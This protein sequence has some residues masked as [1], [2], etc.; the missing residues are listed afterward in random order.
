MGIER[1]GGDAP[2]MSHHLVDVPGIKSGIGG[3]MGG[4]VTEGGHGL[5]VQGDEVG[6]VVLIEGLG[7]LGEG[8]IAIDRISRTGDSRA[9]AKQALLLL[10]RGAIGLLLIAALLDAQPRIAVAGGDV[11]HVEGA[12]DID[13]RIVFAHPGV[14][15]GDIESH[16]FAQAGDLLAQRLHGGGKEV[17][18]QTVRQFPL[19][20]AQP[21]ITGDGARYI[22]ALRLGDIHMQAKAWFDHQQGM[23]E[24]EGAQVGARGKAFAHFDEQGFE[25][26]AQRIRTTTRFRW[27]RLVV[28]NDAPVQQ[29]E[30]GAIVLHDRVVL[31]HALHRGLV[32]GQRTCYDGHWNTLLVGNV[33]C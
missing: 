31:H 30:E 6:D 5:Q 22:K 27:G 28:R 21:A 9:I 2:A 20:V 7:E 16:R 3:D 25:V 23:L 17:L 19:L 18:Q 29:A 14:E 10:F 26:G 1:N 24:Q 12:F 11:A 33:D 13:T 15:V 32:K 8:H 4:Q